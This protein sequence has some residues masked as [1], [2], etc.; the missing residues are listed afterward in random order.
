MKNMLTV[1]R[2]LIGLFLVTTCLS[3]G[4][5]LAQ[6]PGLEVPPV[7]KETEKQDEQPKVPEDKNGK[8]AFTPFGDDELDQPIDKEEALKQWEAQQKEAEDSAKEF[9]NG[10]QRGQQIIIRKSFTTV[11]QNGE[12]QTESSGKMVIVGPD[13]ERKEIELDGTEEMEEL[14]FNFPK[15]P[16]GGP[17]FRLNQ[18]NLKSENEGFAIGSVYRPVNEA[19]RS[20]LNLGDKGLLVLSVSDNSPAAKAGI[21]KHD[22]LIFADDK[23]LETKKD[24]ESVVQLAGEEKQSFSLSLIRKG[25]EI[26]VEVSPIEKSKL[27]SNNVIRLGGDLNIP[28]PMNIPDNNFRKL[29]EDMRKRML[30]NIQRFEQAAEQ[31]NNLNQGF[32]FQDKK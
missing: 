26:S 30:E 25:K 17:A 5:L 4:Q 7:K 27:R 9:R 32:E 22:I 13:G 28:P 8:P 6:E 14:N 11:N 24:L 21:E 31:F 12:K 2:S 20:Q 15:F 29:E 10:R 16:F 3:T 19:M 23:E 18:P 1:V